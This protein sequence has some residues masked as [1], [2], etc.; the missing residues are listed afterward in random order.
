[1]LPELNMRRRSTA[2]EI[3][4]EAVD[5]VRCADPDPSSTAVTTAG[6]PN[7]FKFLPFQG[8]SRIPTVFAPPVLITD[9]NAD[10]EEKTSS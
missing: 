8:A 6:N 4:P 5:I 3:C 10:V 2:D 7:V 1:M 9:M